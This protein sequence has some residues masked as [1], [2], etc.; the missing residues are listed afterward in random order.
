[1]AKSGTVG[2]MAQHLVAAGVSFGVFTVVPMVLVIA[3]M[4]VGNDPGGPMFFPVFLVICFC[5]AAAACLVLFLVCA[6]LQ[7]I[8]RRW[9]FPRWLPVPCAFVLTFVMA[10]SFDAFGSTKPVLASS[11]LAA[12]ATLA[13]AVYWFSLAL[14]GEVIRRVRHTRTCDQ[15]S[16]PGDAPRAVRRLT[17]WSSFALLCILAASRADEVRSVVEAPLI[18]GGGADVVRRLNWTAVSP[19]TLQ[20]MIWAYPLPWLMAALILERKWAR[21]ATPAWP[22]VVSVALGIVGLMAISAVSHEVLSP[23]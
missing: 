1:M 2:F 8:R 13:F 14:S 9:A 17:V 18:G 11:V 3:A 7:L 15:Q 10:I 6:E 16:P 5:Y 21:A 22:Y 4:A 19:E 20:W 12:T 23:I